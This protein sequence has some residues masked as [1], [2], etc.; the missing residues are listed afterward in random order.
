MKVYLVTAG[1]YSSYKVC[2]V[3]S[4]REK[5]EFAKVLYDTTNGIEEYEVDELLSHPAGCFKFIVS[6]DIHGSITNPNGPCMWT[7]GKVSCDHEDFLAVGVK[8]PSTGNV[9]RCVMWAKDLEHAIKIANERRVRIIAANLWEKMCGATSYD[10]E[11]REEIAACLS[12]N[13]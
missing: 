1:D 12:N 8:T 11:V 4:T 9:M 2:C 3:C 7:T 6:M 5:A 10:K 13:A